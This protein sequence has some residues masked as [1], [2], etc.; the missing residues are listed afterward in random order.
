MEDEVLKQCKLQLK[1]MRKI[2][3]KYAD[4][5]NSMEVKT[6]PELKAFIAPGDPTVAKVAVTLKDEFSRKSGKSYSPEFL[7]TLSMAAFHFVSSFDTI[8]VDLP[9][10]FWLSPTEVLELG[11]ADAFDRAIFLCSLLIHLGAQAKVHVLEVEGGLRHPVVIVNNEKCYLFDP[12]PP[13]S[14]LVSDTQAACLSQLAISGRK[15]TRSLFEF[16][17]MTYEEFE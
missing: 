8:G 7:D 3:E 16:N 15:Y 10:S 14:F 4:Q 11:A 12:S 6:I 2:I 1:L 13:A 9:V 5:I 17:S